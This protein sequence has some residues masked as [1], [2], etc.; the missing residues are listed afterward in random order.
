M[1]ILSS[2]GCKFLGIS[3]KSNASENVLTIFFWNCG[4]SRE[5]RVDFFD[6]ASCVQVQV[7]HL[8]LFERF[9]SD[10][11]VDWQRICDDV[12]RHLERPFLEIELSSRV[13]TRLDD[14]AFQSSGIFRRKLKFVEFAV[15]NARK[16]LF[17]NDIFSLKHA[18]RILRELVERA[19]EL[20][21]KSSDRTAL[22]GGEIREE[23]AARLKTN[24]LRIEATRATAVARI[25]RDERGTRAISL[26]LFHRLSRESHIFICEITEV[27]C[28]KYKLE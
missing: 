27:F 1:T 22:F 18:D 10:L 4:I 11:R 12:F 26:E 28:K 19:L 8:V 25:D 2:S 3:S 24:R 13:K 15:R 16:N 9:Q 5:N 21:R 14:D 7:Q 20:K 17:W 23:R 6:W